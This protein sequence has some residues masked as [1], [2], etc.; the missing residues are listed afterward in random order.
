MPVTIKPASHGANVVRWPRQAEDSRNLL[1]RACAK[2][3]KK[4]V[5]LLQSSFDPNLGA[6][7][8]PST[9]GFVHG[10]VLAYSHHHHLRIRP[11]DVWFAI[12]SQISLY[13]NCHAEELREMF[14]AHKGKKELEV[15]LGGLNRYT[16]DFGLFAQMMSDLI[17]KNVLDPELKEW[18]LP[19]FS[20]TTRDDKIV[21]SVLLMGVTQKYFD[22]KFTIMCG[23]PSVT[24]LGQKSDWE[25]VYS[26]LDKFDSFGA[27]PT[28]FCKLLRPVISRFVKSFDEPTSDDT[29][30][31]WQRIAHAKMMG[32]GPSY[33]SGWITAFCFWD[34]KGQSLHGSPRASHSL[35]DTGWEEAHDPVLELDGVTYHK[36]M[37]NEVPPGYTSV[38]VKFDEHGT[39]FDSMMVAGSVGINCT[40][41]G[42]EMDGAVVGLNTMSA[43]TGWWIFESTPP[44]AL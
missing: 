30:G 34:E 5:E 36:V 24:L 26:R 38:P 2:E 18:V 25:L 33:Y 22:F 39:L 15:K 44:D 37:S 40:S 8:Q 13:I 4:C 27:E 19:A 28:Q 9:N 23:L 3:G 14:V 32:S 12:I 42:D 21:A 11:E 20:T 17:D 31:F 16:V 43:E 29:I 10:A 6:T 1:D 41:S 35:G 7:I